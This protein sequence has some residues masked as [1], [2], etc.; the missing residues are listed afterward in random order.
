MI[1]GSARR[2][3]PDSTRTVSVVDGTPGGDQFAGSCQLPARSAIQA[4]S[5]E[6]S[7]TGKAGKRSHE[8]HMAKRRGFGLGWY[9]R[10][11]IAGKSNCTRSI[12]SSR[13]R[14]GLE[15]ASA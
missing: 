1:T 15:Q 14:P 5:A 2:T 11:D 6:N 10:G 4:F 9:W 7:V 8:S 13:F 3:E 12:R